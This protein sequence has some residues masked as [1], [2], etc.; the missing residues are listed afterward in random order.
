VRKVLAYRALSTRGTAVAEHLPADRG[1]ESATTTNVCNG[2]QTDS[3][4]RHDVAAL[5]AARRA[6]GAKNNTSALSA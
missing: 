3:D 5:V 2:E 4:E 1:E 6:H